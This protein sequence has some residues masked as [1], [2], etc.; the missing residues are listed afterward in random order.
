MN[1]IRGDACLV[2]DEGDAFPPNRGEVVSD[3]AVESKGGGHL[4]ELTCKLGRMISLLLAAALGLGWQTPSDSPRADAP[5]Q[6]V[7]S[8]PMRPISEITPTSFRLQYFT[9]GPCET[10]VQVRKSTIPASAFHSPANWDVTSQDIH[11]EGERRFHEVEVGGLEPGTM[12]FYR[13]YD[14]TLEPSDSERRYGAKDGWRREYA[15]STEALAGKRTI[16]RVP[17]KV[18][19]MTNVI[20]LPVPRGVAVPPD[21]TDQQLETIKDEFATAARFFFVN[22]GMRYWADFQITVDSRRQV[23]GKPEDADERFSGWPTSRS[24]DGVDYR[25]PGGGGFTFFDPTRPA[26]VF[27]EP[28]A[29]AKPSA[30]Q[31]EVAFLR[32]YDPTSKTWKYRNSG[33]GTLGFDGYPN[34]EHGRS[35]FLGGGDI[36]W[37]VTHEFHHQME[38]ASNF[39]LSNREDERIVFNHYA[40]RRRTPRADGS[41]DEQ[42]WTT[43]GR[44]GEHWDGMA[45][46]DRKL[47][48]AQWLRYYF[49]HPEVFDDADQDGFPDNAPELPLD[50]VR[51]GSDPRNPKTD[52]LMNDKDKAMLSTWAP[53]PLHTTWLKKEV[54]THALPQPTLP[55]SDGDGLADGVDPHPLSPYPGFVWAFRPTVDGLADEWDG[56]P[57]A[58][59]IDVP[60]VEA[61]FSHAQDGDAYFGM[62]VLGKDWKQANVTL[63]GEGLGVYSGVGVQSVKVLRDGE[64][65]RVESGPFAT[66]NLKFKVGSR[67]GSTVVEFSLANHENGWYWDR[68]GR[69][70]GWALAVSDSDGAWFSANDA[71]HLVY[72][73]MLEPGGAF[74]MPTNPPAPLGADATS[75]S[76]G[77]SKAKLGAGWSVEGGVWTHQGAESPLVVEVPPSTSFDLYVEMSGI[78][79]LV[80]GAFRASTPEPNAGVDYVAFV[81]GYGNTT[82]KMRIF[83]NEVGD[84]DKVVV[85]GKFHQIQFSR[86][87]GEL[88]VLLDGKPI[89]YGRDPQPKTPIT[90]LA[91]LGGHMNGQK[92][93]ML[94]YR[95]SP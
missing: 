37:L 86:R 55:D 61:E 10:R 85:P 91:V 5:A 54:R 80:L 66:P 25:D 72:D 36:A 50:E 20:G 23:W 16:M 34:G 18:V 14:P 57:P 82:S 79:D 4:F 47:S 88:W 32:T 45:F 52:G 48:D 3:P 30:H 44:H 51:F 33:G 11:L 71:Y 63:D 1:I 21:F 95:A 27:R 35:Q 81:G 46:W 19:L 62:L 28:F 40:P 38:S 15:V 7:L 68:G 6:P 41:Y 92:V 29:E 42:S 87:E 43:S 67:N 75:L 78:G 70:I 65:V 93:R 9:A 13:V 83:G 73:T 24:Y 26:E 39:G 60:S 89:L 31:I 2:A 58:G 53:A 77:D 56:V 69:E 94:R 76:P 49:G 12:Y 8:D 90:K 17:I 59:S 22:S 84:S 74:P 64:A